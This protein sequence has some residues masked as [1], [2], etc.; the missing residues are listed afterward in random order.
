M[1]LRFAKGPAPDG[2]IGFNRNKTLINESN[3]SIFSSAPVRQI[4]ENKWLYAL[5]QLQNNPHINHVILAYEY[6]SKYI[7]TRGTTNN[8]FIQQTFY[9]NNLVSSSIMIIN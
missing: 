9:A 6:S 3:Y 5:T 2:S 7:L 4:P 8:T 1:P